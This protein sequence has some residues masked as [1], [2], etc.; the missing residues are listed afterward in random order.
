MFLMMDLKYFRTALSIMIIEQRHETST[1]V[2]CATSKASKQPAHKRRLIRAF[3]IRLNVL[4]LTEHHLEFL[5]LK[6]G[7]TG[8]SVSKLFKMAHFW[9]SHVEAQFISPPSRSFC[10]AIMW[11]LKSTSML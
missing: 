3:A 5:S 9:K 1:N 2:V 6:E 10:T 4:L 8:S 11:G 7:C